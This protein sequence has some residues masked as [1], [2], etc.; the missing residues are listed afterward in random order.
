MRPMVSPIVRYMAHTPALAWSDALLYLDRMCVCLSV[1]MS[2]C[3]YL[4]VYVCVLS[5]PVNLIR[6]LLRTFSVPVLYC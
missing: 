2:V 3:V 4:R 1:L 6:F 5:S